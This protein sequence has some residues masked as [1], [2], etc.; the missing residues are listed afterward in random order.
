MKTTD[1]LN[2]VLAKTA[3]D[4]IN[5]FLKSQAD[6]LITSEHPFAAF[7]REKIHQKG[8]TQQHVFISANMS[9]NYGYKII[10]EEKHTR[11]RDTILRLCLASEFT[12]QETQKALTL[13]HLP[14]LYARLP[15]D[16]VFIIAFN[17]GIYDIHEVDQLLKTHDL[18]PLLSNEE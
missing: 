6:R 8:L 10:S 15:R 9:E 2:E 11:Q 4:D 13:Y 5:V 17:K 7:M 18:D 16:A 12:L 1:S 3:P 14:Q